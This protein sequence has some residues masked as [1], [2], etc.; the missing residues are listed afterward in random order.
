MDELK[1]LNEAIIACQ[2]CPRLAPYVRE[3]ARVKVRR[4]R[5]E[6]YWGRAV[7]SFGDP[8][9][10]LLIVGL[11]PAAHG[12]NRTGRMFTGDS[13]GDW[14][15]SALHL[16]GFASQP[17]SSH[18]SDGLE[19]VESYI[20]SMAH[21]APPQ[22]KPTSLEIATCRPFLK[23]ELELLPNLEVILC[24]GGLAFRE[25]C[26]LKNLKGLKFG[27]NRSWEL[28]GGLRLVSSYHPSRQ[29]TNTGRLTRPD[30]EK[31]FID[32]RDSLNLDQD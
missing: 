17:D 11:A 24:L 16:A 21:C 29:N 18:R 27:H 26:R 5:E 7:P 23:K 30:W 4:H 20:S 9:G 25:I 31:V 15:F 13:S 22:N 3:V 28:E 10:R 8:L 14:L 19:L 6:E 2:K 32:I 1:K 12:A